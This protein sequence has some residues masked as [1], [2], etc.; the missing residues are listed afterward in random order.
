MHRLYVGTPCSCSGSLLLILVTRTGAGSRV[1]GSRNCKILR[2]ANAFC[3]FWPCTAVPPALDYEHPLKVLWSAAS[4]CLAQELP[5]EGL[6][7]WSSVVPSGFA[8]VWRRRTAKDPPPATPT[9][10]PAAAGKKAG[11]GS[12]AS[13]APA[14][15]GPVAAAAAVGSGAA[16]AHLKLTAE[17]A[18]ASSLLSYPLT[19]LHCLG[20]PGASAVQEPTAGSVPPGGL[21]AGPSKGRGEGRV[22]AAAAAGAAASA[23]ALGAVR[24]RLTD[25]AAAAG[26]PL[27]VCVLGASETAELAQP[28]V[29]RVRVG[30]GVGAC[31]V[32]C[33]CWQGRRQGWQKKGG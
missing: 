4:T 2:I 19:L 11:S 29:W 22:G 9:T 23:S 30:A 32:S 18:V 5:S 24:E 16:D 20:A 25:R 14:T 1:G 17:L 28:R 13:A 26:A 15:A 21:G 10:V 12:K 3:A 6:R 33:G 27:V 8:S 7:D 31:R